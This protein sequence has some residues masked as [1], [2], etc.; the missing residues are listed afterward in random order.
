VGLRTVWLHWQ[1]TAPELLR[2]GDCCFVPVRM[3][4]SSPKTLIVWLMFSSSSCGFEIPSLSSIQ[5]FDCVAA[6][7]IKVLD[8]G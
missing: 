8:T 2:A 4:L 1:G 6:S 5:N 3:S 7:R